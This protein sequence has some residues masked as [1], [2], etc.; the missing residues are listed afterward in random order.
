[1]R[2]YDTI[3]IGAGPAGLMAAREFEA[4]KINYLII[5]AKN[6]IGLPLKCGEI[7]QQETFL[8]LFG[9]TDY[10]FIRNKIS[11]ILFRVKGAEK[12]INKNMI[13]LDKPQFLEWLAEPIKDHLMLNTKLKRINEKSE[14]LQIKTSKGVFQTKLVILACGTKYHVQKDFKLLKKDIELIPCIGGLFNNTTLDRDMA[15]FFYHQ[16]MGIALWAFPKEN[17]IVNAGAG[18]ILKNKEKENLNLWRSFRYLTNKFEIPLDGEPSYAGRYVTSGPIHRTYSDR[19][20]VC[21]DAAGQVFAG[22]GEGIYFSLKAGQLAGQAAT[23]AIE[24]DMF[25]RKF[26][27]EY[28]VQWKKSFGRQMNAGIVLATTLFFLMK[29]KLVLKMLKI[30][31]PG[32]IL[33]I[34]FNGIVSLRIRLFYYLIKMLGYAPRR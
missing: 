2:I 30:M 33:N 34:W 29:H 8:K 6:K 22:I 17:D 24:N 26:L 10:S 14:S 7:T 21:G 12:I 18:I 13:M 31:T 27:K 32:E 15:Y 4:N 9:H 25:D 3:I 1:M 23:K 19:L 20:L 28:E 16:D 11:S 5:E